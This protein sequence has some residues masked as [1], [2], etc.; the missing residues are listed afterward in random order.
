MKMFLP[1]G[2]AANSISESVV[3][4]CWW[5]SPKEV[6]QGKQLFVVINSFL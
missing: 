1:I 6:G 5:Q 4:T 3:S 2:Q